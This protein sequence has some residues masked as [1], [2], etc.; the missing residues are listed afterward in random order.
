MKKKIV[1]HDTMPGTDASP[2]MAPET[3]TKTAKQLEKE[4]DF[5]SSS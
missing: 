4:M 5:S 1:R 2:F 3:I